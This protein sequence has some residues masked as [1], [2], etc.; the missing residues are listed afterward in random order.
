MSKETIIARLRKLRRMTTSRGCTE[1]EALAAAEKAAQLMREHRLSEA[2]IELDWQTRKVAST[3]RSSR[4][5]LWSAIGRC[6]NS[7]PLVIREADGPMLLFVGGEPGP[8]I[9]HY[10]REVTERAVDRALREF[11]REKF[12]RMRRTPATRRH[13]AAEFSDA[14]I[15]RLCVRLLETFAEERSEI[16]FNAALA[17]RDGQYSDSQAVA[18]REVKSRYSEARWMGD[19]AGK[20]VALSRGVNEAGGP[21]QIIG[22]AEA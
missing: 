11:K 17:A 18:R 16:A 10:L 12:Y 1:A 14:M 7:A 9:A 13:A 20:K 6:T 3:S 2:E 8:E 15:V 22:R 5:K 4:S 19:K 21:A